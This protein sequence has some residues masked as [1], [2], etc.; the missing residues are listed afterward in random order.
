MATGK[1]APRLMSS[2]ACHRESV[3]AADKIGTRPGTELD[4]ADKDTSLRIRRR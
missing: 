2:P 1:V 3:P 4:Y